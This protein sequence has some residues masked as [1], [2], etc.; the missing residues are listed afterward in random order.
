M[1]QVQSLSSLRS[2]RDRNRRQVLRCIEQSPGISRKE[3]TTILQLTD[4][5]V[6]RICREVIDCGI[7]VEDF[8]DNSNGRPGRRHVGLRI[9][10]SGAYVIAA[11]LTAFD[12]SIALVDLEGTQI[13]HISLPESDFSDFDTLV[14]RIISE[15]RTLIK[16]HAIPANRILGMAAVTAGSV[17]HATG[18]VKRCSLHAL[19]SMPLASAL[20]AELGFPVHL[21]TIGNALN[22]AHFRTQG[23]F[24]EKEAAL[25]V[26]VAFGMGASW[27]IGGR[28]FRSEYDERTIGHVPIDSIEQDNST[29]LTSASGYAIVS[30][31]KGVRAEDTQ[32]NFATIYQPADLTQAVDAAKDGDAEIREIFFNAGVTLGENLFSISA[33]IPPDHITL[34]GPVSQVAAYQ[35]GAR[36][37]IEESFRKSRTPVPTISFS[38]I[39]YLRA[40]ELFALE[41]FLFHTPLDPKLL[42]G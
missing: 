26:H 29:L 13:D 34:A 23:K 1:Q 16:R 2:I 28:P 15:T 7:V 17:S 6:S 12:K 27:I 19:A 9:K 21:E 32:E 18:T 39:D 5:G 8:Q 40:T 31:L 42:A 3:M 20:Q 36:R 4:A 11:C 38:S 41:D 35:D 25:L 33:T 30:R 37:G 24:S 10:A 22:V 14:D